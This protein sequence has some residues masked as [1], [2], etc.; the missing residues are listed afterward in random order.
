MFLLIYTQTS[1]RS[2]G[3]CCMGKT[4]RISIFPPMLAAAL[5]GLT[6]CEQ[7]FTPPDNHPEFGSLSGLVLDQETELPVADA[8]ITALKNAVADTTDSL[9]AFLL[10]SLALGTDTI[11]V[12]L[13][14]YDT[15]YSTISIHEGPQRDTIYLHPTDTTVIPNDT[16][17]EWRLLGLEGECITAIAVDPFDENIIYVGSDI[18]AENCRVGG[19]FKSTDGGAVWDTLIRGTLLGDINIPPYDQDIIYVLG[20]NFGIGKSVDGGYTWSPADKGLPLGV[21]EVLAVMAVDPRYPD[22]LYAGSGG[23]MGGNLYKSTDGGQSWNIIGSP[24]LGNGVSAI[25]IDPTNTQTLFAGTG[26]TSYIYKSEDGGKNWSRQGFQGEGLIR[27]IMVHQVYPNIVYAGAYGAGFYISQDGG[28]TWQLANNGIMDGTIGMFK[29]DISDTKVYAAASFSDTSA[30][31]TSS[32]DNISWTIV[33]GGG[34]NCRIES[35][36]YAPILEKLFIG[37]KNG[38]YVL[39]EMGNY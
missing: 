26:W 18:T 8:A 1:D 39:S 28:A 38:I 15:K 22:T 35:I 5:L 20:G 14:L 33:G 11:M 29:I 13:V 6:A 10:D 21:E 16:L 37:N 7:P 9:G 32:P 3:R 31:Y 19:L 2:L 25:A 36:C 34:F 27:S 12:T 17:G 30:V 23:V 4:P 24:T